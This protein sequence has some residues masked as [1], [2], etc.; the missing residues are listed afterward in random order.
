M[1]GQRVPAI[2]SLVK[3]KRVDG[4][5]VLGT[6]LRHGYGTTE[7]GVVDP[8]DAAA[9]IGQRVQVG[10]RDLEAVKLICVQARLLR[11]GRR[12][13]FTEAGS[14][15]DTFADWHGYRQRPRVD[16]ETGEP[17]GETERV[18]IYTTQWGYKDEIPH[19]FPVWI[20]D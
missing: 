20:E 11:R 10:T 1:T 12:F 16:Q 14:F 13:Y 2:G 4:S 5:R 3:G 18:I 19:N 9:H 8:L 7:L 6:V 15:P 17:T